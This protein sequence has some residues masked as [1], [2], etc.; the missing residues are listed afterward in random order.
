M[1]GQNKTKTNN[2]NEPIN[3]EPN[4]E[5][6]NFQNLLKQVLTVPKEKVDEKRAEQEREKKRAG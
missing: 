3:G 6:D 1:A 4:P 5:F 2:K